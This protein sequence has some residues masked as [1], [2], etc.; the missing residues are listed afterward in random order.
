MAILEFLR[1]AKDTLTLFACFCPQL[2]PPKMPHLKYLA[3]TTADDA[4]QLP[5]MP[6]HNQLDV[7]ACPNLEWEAV[8]DDPDI[9]AVSKTQTSCDEVSQFWYAYLGFETPLVHGGNGSWSFLL[10]QDVRRIL[11]DDD[12]F[13]E[14]TAANRVHESSII[15]SQSQRL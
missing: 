9:L 12:A 13:V 3:T 8:R 1:K 11:Q 2:E 5:G 7:F 14:R 4:C 10:S 6:H 15:H